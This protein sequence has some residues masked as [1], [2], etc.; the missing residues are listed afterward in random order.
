M[1]FHVNNNWQVVSN[2]TVIPATNDEIGT[3][4]YEL[5][6]IEL[7]NNIKNSL[8]SK[9]ADI[10]FPPNLGEIYQLDVYSDVDTSNNLYNEPEALKEDMDDVKYDKYINMNITFHKGDKTLSG[11]VIRQ[12]RDFEG[13]P[14]ETPRKIPLL[15]IRFY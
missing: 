12:K 3:D 7:D 10:N 14:I 9:T 1:I 2:S 5:Q 11:T 15:D 8:E 13:N 4:T 6:L